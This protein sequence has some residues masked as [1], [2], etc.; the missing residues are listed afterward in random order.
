MSLPEEAKRLLRIELKNLRDLRKKLKMYML[1]T[2]T[3][4]ALQIMRAKKELEEYLTR[5][6][7]LSKIFTRESRLKDLHLPNVVPS[8]TADDL[9]SSS[10]VANSFSTAWAQSHMAEVPFN[11]IPRI[12]R[13]VA[14]ETARSYSDVVDEAAKSLKLS[15]IWNSILDAKTCARCKAMDGEETQPGETFHGGLEPGYMHPACRC[16]SSIIIKT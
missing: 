7:L 2:M 13:I 15:R 12:N 9:A 5:E 16:Y 8:S 10:L 1:A 3:G 14:T 4:G 11:W 6:V